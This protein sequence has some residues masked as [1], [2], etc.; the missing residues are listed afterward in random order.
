MKMTTEITHRYFEFNPKNGADYYALISTNTKE[1]AINMYYDNISDRDMET[2]VDCQEL[3]S[4]EAWNKLK[5]CDESEAEL[6][7]EEKLE[8]F[9]SN[10][11]LLWPQF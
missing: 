8:E 5:N 6:S 2:D 9:E 3:S 1:E 7:T 10:G 11:V 4:P